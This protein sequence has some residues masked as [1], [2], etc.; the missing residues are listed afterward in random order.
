MTAIEKTQSQFDVVKLLVVIAT[1]VAGIWAFHNY[2]EQ[3]IL[4]YRVLALLAVVAL[5][6]VI[7][8][9][10]LWGKVLWGYLRDCRTELRKVVWPTRTETTQTTL[11]VVVV[12]VLTGLFL[13]GMD[14][15]F[16]WLVQQLLAL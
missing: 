9:Q 2:A 11:I 14:L 6:I 4:L 12:V 7:F 10:T 8:Y 3:F 1:L 15:F 16:G 13:C 5:S